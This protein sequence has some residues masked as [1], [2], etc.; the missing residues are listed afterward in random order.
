M[1]ND[2]WLQTDILIIGGGMAGMMA[3]LEARRNNCSVII[4]KKGEGASPFITAFNV[5]IGHTSPK[6]FFYDTVKGGENLNNYKLVKLLVQNAIPVLKDLESYGV[7]FDKF[8]GDHVASP[9]Q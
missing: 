1:N 8:N 7:E 5:P 9:C 3:A 2:I 4:A 6:D